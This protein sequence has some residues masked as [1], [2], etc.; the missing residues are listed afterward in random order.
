MLVAVVTL[1]LSGYGGFGQTPWVRA[2]QLPIFRFSPSLHSRL[3]S[4]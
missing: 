1:W 4:N 2:P 3:I